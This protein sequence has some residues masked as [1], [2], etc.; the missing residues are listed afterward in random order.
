MST[1]SHVMFRRRSRYAL[2]RCG[3]FG[4]S[5]ALVVLIV[6]T[7]SGTEGQPGLLVSVSLV[8][9][10]LVLV[11][12]LYALGGWRLTVTLDGSMLIVRGLRTIEL[13]LACVESVTWRGWL[14]E[15]MVLTEGTNGGGRTGSVP[16]GVRTMFGIVNVDAW[17]ADDA[18]AL[19][20][21]VFERLPAGVRFDARAAGRF[22]AVGCQLD[23]PGQ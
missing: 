3:L 6:V 19:L 11:G 7:G 23:R 20:R 10:L 9:G 12:I 16:V 15:A 8:V 22:S 21:S 14:E 1:Y 4:C 18:Q 2:T 17:Q 13:D 5:L